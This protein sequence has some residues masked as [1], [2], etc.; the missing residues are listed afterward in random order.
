MITRIWRGLALAV[1][2]LALSG[3]Q[4]TSKLT[5]RRNRDGQQ[6]K[7]YR[8]RSLTGIR[9]G[10]K[11]GC[12]L[13]VADRQDILTMQM[14]FQIAAV[15]RLETGSYVW[16]RKDAPEIKGSVKADA[17]TFQGNQDGPPS[18]GGTFQLVSDDVDLYQVKVPATPMD[19]PGRRPASSK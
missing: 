9:D 18:I 4:D 12:E 7:E 6:L 5:I 15:P 8:L 16:Q 10:D 1:A 13:V 19:A 3:C 11:L 17:I 2:A 14:R